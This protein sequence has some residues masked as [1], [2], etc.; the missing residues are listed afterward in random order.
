M[1]LARRLLPVVVILAIGLVHVI[2][3][4]PGHEWGDDFALYLLHARNLVEGRPYA[5]TGYIYNPHYPNIGPPTYPPVA[6]ALLAPVYALA[7]LNLTLLKLVMVGCFV[8]FLAAAYLLFRTGLDPGRALL[9]IVLVGLNWFFLQATNTIGSDELFL[10]FLYLTLLLMEKRGQ[11]GPSSSTQTVLSATAGL[12][13][14]LA[15]GTRSLGALAIVALV[16]QELVAWRRIG[17]STLV[18][19]AVFAVL[20]SLQA[21]LVHSDRYYLDQFRGGPGV[22]VEHAAWYAERLAAFWSNGVW[23][24]PAV[25]LAGASLLLAAAGFALRARRGVGVC[26]VFALLYAAVILLWPSYEA[27]RYLFPVI[28]LVVFYLFCGFDH[29]WLTRRP[30]LRRTAFGLLLAGTAVS[31]VSRYATL[32]WGPSRHGVHTAEA[33]KLF[34]CIVDRTRPDDVVLFAKPRAMALMTR[35]PSAAPF[36]A[37]DDDQLWSYIQQVKAAYLVVARRD[38]VFGRAENRDL[39]EYLRALVARSPE[40]FAQICANSD[41]TLYRIQAD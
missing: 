34:Q 37:N 3:L 9:A 27:E 41:F 16:I 12:T 1:S 25:L 39:S 20:A 18:T 17:R 29:P 19:L 23:H 6:P 7:G 26:E 31:Y 28:P 15:F 30:G 33:Q 5:Q 36:V 21:L 35:R 38:G 24:G 40:R 4:R 14:Y 8:G 11:A 10:A 2:T 32:D 13:A 22:L